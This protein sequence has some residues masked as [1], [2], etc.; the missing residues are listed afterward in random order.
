MIQDMKKRNPDL[1][2]VDTRMS[3]TYSLRKQEIVEDEPPVSEL[4]VRWLAFFTERQQI[5]MEFTRLVSMDLSKSFYGG[6]GGHLLKHLQLFR[7]KR[8]EGM[9]EMSAILESL[10][11]DALNQRKRTAI[12]QALPWYLREN[13]SKFLKLCEPT[14]RKDV[15]KGMTIGILAVV[16][17]VK[18]PLPAIYSDVVLVMKEHAVLRKLGDVPNA[19]MNLMGLLY[20]LNMNYPKDLRY[21]FEVIQRL[22]MGI[23]IESCTARVHT[24]KYKLLS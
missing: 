6:L 15:I 7:S 20:A 12:L 23:G 19:F 5:S 1:A 18:E 3:S 24:L 11:K 17:D 13:P 4:M 22:F 9:T 8:F 14:D 16:E 2:F 21:T 10:D